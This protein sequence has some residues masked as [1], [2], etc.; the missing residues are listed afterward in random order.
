[1]QQRR[2]LQPS[3]HLLNPQQRSLRCRLLAV[4]RHPVQLKLQPRQPPFDPLQLHPSARGVLHLCHRKL[5]HPLVEFRAL[6]ISGHRAQQG[7]HQD[8]S[9]GDHP[10]QNA[11]PLPELSAHGSALRR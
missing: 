11:H 9:H 3:P 6:R 2:P 8:Q 5:P 7:N 10:K 4:D 1:M